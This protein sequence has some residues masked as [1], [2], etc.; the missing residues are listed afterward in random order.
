MIYRI[1][2]TESTNSWMAAHLGDSLDAV[3]CSRQ[4]AGR[5][6]RGNHWE[7]EDGKNICMSLLY[8][9]VR[10]LASDYFR[11]S[12]AV[13]TAVCLCLQKFLKRDDIRIKWPNDIYVGDSKICGI[14]IENRL[15]GMRISH[16]IAGIGLNV[17]QEVF[18]SDAPNP[19]SMK[20][21]S[22][23]DH[24]LD[25]VLECLMDQLKTQLEM[26]ETD[27]KRLESLFWENLYR[28]DGVFPYQDQENGRFDARIVGID[29]MGRLCLQDEKTGEKR[30]YAFKE[31]SFIV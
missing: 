2:E 18:L 28:R 24:P 21:L 6:Q 13:A 12:E 7:S 16:S 14:L 4:T 9:P 27:P 15:E 10:I 26:A 17:N 19:V 30:W 8:K 20:Q 22:G 23:T 5:G 3:V 31:V 11:L 1:E 29:A 25:E